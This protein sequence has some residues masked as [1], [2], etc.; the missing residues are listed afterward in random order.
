H[1]AITGIAWRAASATIRSRWPVKKTSEL[2]RSAPAP[3]RT[4]VAK[5]RL[6]IGFSDRSRDKNLSPDRASCLLH[7]CR[8]PLRVRI[9]RIYQQGDDPGRGYDLVQK[10]KLRHRL[11]VRFGP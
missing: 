7:D 11:N 6:E 8:I 3:S 10:P 1:A 5:T 4:R 2:T 9:V